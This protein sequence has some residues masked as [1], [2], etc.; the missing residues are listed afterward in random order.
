LF[1][2]VHTAAHSGSMW[3]TST[4]TPPAGDFTNAFVTFD[5]GAV[6]TL[7]RMKVWNY[8]EAVSGVN[9]LTRRGVQT[10]N[11]S[12][13]GED[14]VFT[15]NI[16]NQS[17]VRAPGI[18]TNFGQTISMG[19]VAARYVR[20]NVLTNYGEGDNR[21]GLSEVQFFDTNLPPRVDFASRNYSSNKV[22]VLFSES[23]T[24]STATNVANYSIKTD[25]TNSANVLSAAM[26]LYNNRIVLETTPLANSSYTLHV[27]N[28]VSA[29]DGTITDGSPVTIEREVVLWLKA[30]AG[31]TADGGGLVS[32][33]DDQSGNNNNAAQVDPLYQPTLVPGAINGQPVVHFTGGVGFTNYMLAPHSPSLLV[34]AGDVSIFAVMKFQTLNTFNTIVSKI[35][36][37]TQPAPFDSFVLA[38][39]QVR[40]L[41][42]NGWGNN[43]LNGLS[44]I[45]TAQPYVLS[46]VTRGTN[47]TEYLNGAFNGSVATLHGCA[48]VASSVAIGARFPG[49]ATKLDGDIAELM[50][51]R[52]AVSDSERTAIHDY[53][54]AKYGVPIVNLIFN[55]QPTN[56]TKLEGQKAT[57]KVFVTASSPNITYQWQ[58]FGT[59]IPNATNATYT[60]PYLTVAGDNN[61]TFRVLVSVPSSS[62]FSDTVTLTVIPDLE[63]PT[64]ISAGRKIWNP[65]EI[66]VVFSERVDAA[67]ATAAGNYTLDNGGSVTSA[68]YGETT[69]KIVLTTT[70]LTTNGTYLL[71]VQNINDLY[72]N[73]IVPTQVPVGI[74]PVAA[75]WLKA[76]AGV[77]TDGSGLVTQWDDQSGNGN[78][79]TP[80]GG[81]ESYPLLTNGFNNAPVLH[82][83]ISGTTLTTNYLACN[84][85]ESLALT[86]DMS[87]YAVASF[88]DYATHRN[89]INKTTGRPR[90]PGVWS[91]D[92]A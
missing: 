67:T 17:F 13:A 63:K 82:F 47:G 10:A 18:F 24:L 11:I 28:V 30:D 40:F 75:L 59:N 29:V 44:N 66:V 14:L 79:A 33:W 68:S 71:N 73:T 19:G 31:V 43:T 21:V 60:T 3:L 15:T 78:N 20:I 35:H 52:G 9:V 65:S 50:V 76:D 89:I 81:P 34:R 61:S 1:G 7:D 54:G 80:F 70:G 12:V 5:L 87:I 77:T 25:G 85:S 58:R 74:Y 6:R 51:V 2:D 86:G 23:V 45:V 41:R 26:D 69:D 56:M 92:P 90:D 84:P 42:G 27:S 32:G 91:F 53:L 83:G 22:T 88:V 72:T 37:N 39:G 36:T 55:Q 57:F 64:I 38:S 4:P 62:Q 8:N 49:F 16:F 48:D 46:F